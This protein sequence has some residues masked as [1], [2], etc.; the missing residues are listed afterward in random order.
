MKISSTLITVTSYIVS[1]VLW[2]LGILTFL[3]NILGLWAP[4]HLACFGFVLFI[5]IPI[6]LNIV[7]I[8]FS[9]VNEE[10][11]I[12]RKYLIINSISLGISLL[13]IAFTVIVSAGWFW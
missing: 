10:K 2:L 3:F 8:I 5:P 6:I 13:F 7:A 12:R 11:N 1:G 4:W 9:A